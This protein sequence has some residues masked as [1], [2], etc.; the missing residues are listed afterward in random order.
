MLGEINTNKT[1]QLI[2]T[3]EK[4]AAQQQPVCCLLVGTGPEEAKLK[5]YVK[6]RSL[7]GIVHFLGYRQ[8]IPGLMAGADVVVNLSRR[9]GLPRVVIEAMAAG[10]PVV[11]TGVRGNKDLVV[12]GQTGF[13][14][15]L[16]NIDATAEALL[17]LMADASLRQQMGHSGRERAGDCDINK[18][19]LEMERL[20]EQV[21]GN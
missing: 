19:V 20:Y 17:K 8:D 14:V 13:V 11:A 1:M 18:T 7:M 2:K 3:M 15:P 16:D 9:E 4:L 5:D 10:K 6:S 12:D 21:I